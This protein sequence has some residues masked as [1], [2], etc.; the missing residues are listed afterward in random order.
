M[1]RLLTLLTLTAAI[2]I[3]GVSVPH[4]TVQAQ[5]Y[6]GS[7]PNVRAAAGTSLRAP[8]TAGTITYGGATQAITADAT[9]VLTTASQS[10]CSAPGYASCNFVYWTSGTSLSVTTTAATAFTPGNVI[11]AFIT[12]SSNDILTVVPAQYN[13]ASPSVTQTDRFYVASPDTCVFTYL[14]TAAAAG[15]PK[16]ELAATSQPTYS[17]TTDTTAGTVT[18]TCLLPSPASRTTSGTG[19]TVTGIDWLYSIVTTTATSIT[20]PIVNSISAP[21]T[22]GGAAAGTVAAAGGSLTLLPTSTNWQKTAVTSGLLYRGAITFGTPFA[23][24]TSTQSLSTTLAVVTA[25]S[26]ATK[27]QLG[28]FIVRY[29]AAQ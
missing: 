17:T 29:K 14:T 18:V 22:A 27:I 20:D 7:M 3:A 5:G 2:L 25:G 12:T 13:V 8:Y 1:R 23:Y 15:W 24:N 10:D 26:T 28:G 19:A 16:W 6:S 9:G 21:A 4:K 11:V